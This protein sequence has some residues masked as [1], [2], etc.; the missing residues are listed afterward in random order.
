MEKRED[1]IRY[2]RAGYNCAQSVV[3]ACAGEN[4]INT[5]SAAAFGGGIGRM[6]SI[7]GAVTGAYI[8]LGLQHGTKTIPTEEDKLNLYL[9]AKAFRKEF[10]Q[11]NSTDICLELLGEDMNSPEGKARIKEKDLHGKI[12]EKCILDAIDIM[13]KLQ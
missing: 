12:C 6:Q 11:R 5:K 7:C 4:E 3:L 8:C 9:K 13:E 2:F 1:A 10:I